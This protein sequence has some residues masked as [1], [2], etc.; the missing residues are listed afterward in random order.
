MGTPNTPGRKKLYNKT[1]QDA[2]GN[3]KEKDSAD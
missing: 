2:C 1:S 3:G